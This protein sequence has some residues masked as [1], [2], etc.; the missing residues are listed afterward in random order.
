MHV[1]SANFVLS[2]IIYKKSYEYPLLH[3]YIVYEPQTSYSTFYIDSPYCVS[4][5]IFLFL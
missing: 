4:E 1:Y 2:L 3:A 5:E